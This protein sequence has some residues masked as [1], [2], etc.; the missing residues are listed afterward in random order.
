[1][2]KLRTAVSAALYAIGWRNISAYVL[3]LDP[4]YLDSSPDAPIGFSRR[5]RGDDHS[6]ERRGKWKGLLLGT[7]AMKVDVRKYADTWITNAINSNEPFGVADE[8]AGSETESESVADEGAGSE[9]RSQSESEG[10][11]INVRE[12]EKEVFAK[13]KDGL[14]FDA[15]R[16]L[17]MHR[18]D[19]WEIQAPVVGTVG[20]RALSSLMVLLHKGL[21]EEDDAQ[22]SMVSFS[23][24][25]RLMSLVQRT[26]SFAEMSKASAGIAGLLDSKK[27]L[28]TSS[29]L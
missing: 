18:P 26:A 23:S 15:G 27:S 11:T 10:G 4:C 3:S 25:R 24:S 1:M 9:A 20:D 12:S 14:K 16:W 28:M 5:P 21:H 2:A 22:A 19:R 7:S 17:R 8:G 6:A 29:R 13:G